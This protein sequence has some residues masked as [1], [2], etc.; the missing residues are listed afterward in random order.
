MEDKRPKYEFEENGL[1]ELE[2]TF[3]FVQVDEYY[4]DIFC[5]VAYIFLSVTKGHYFSNGNK[6]LATVLA[7]FFIITN[8]H[9]IRVI[10]EKRVK[11]WFNKYFPDYTL[12][13]HQVTINDEPLYH[14]NKVILSDSSYL[15]FSFCKK[16]V[17]EYFAL[18]II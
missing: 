17:A 12:D 16:I 11:R 3:E 1:R 9:T 15:D 8:S 10:D 7:A 4:P 18:I 5:K 2:K 6:R 14:L 13:L